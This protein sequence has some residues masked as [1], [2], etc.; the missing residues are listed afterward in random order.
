MRDLGPNR[1][2]REHP[3]NKPNSGVASAWIAPRRSPV[4][5]RLA[6]SEVSANAAGS[7]WSL[8]R[9]G[10]PRSASQLSVNLMSDGAA[11]GEGRDP[12]QGGLRWDRPPPAASGSSAASTASE[13]ASTRSADAT[14]L[15]LRQ[16]EETQPRARSDARPTSAE[17]V[18]APPPLQTAALLEKAG[19]GQ[20]R[21]RTPGPRPERKRAR[22]VAALSLNAGS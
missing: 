10:W 4:R 20:Y 15:K 12:R 8:R 9:C 5:V 19:A 3:A 14:V 21:H 2:G 11:R 18:E 17:S 16:Q 1:H 7:S 13:T 22:S 6:P